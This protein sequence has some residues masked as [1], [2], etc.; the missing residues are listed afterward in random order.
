MWN[1]VKMSL[2]LVFSF[3]LILSL[4]KNIFDYQKKIQ[5][6]NSYKND[7]E[8]EKRKNLALKS[9]IQRSKDLYSKEADIR[10]KLNLLKPGELTVIIPITLTPTP[11]PQPKKEIFQQWLELF[12]K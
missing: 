1:K 11:P 2:F 7:P 9:Q 3:F 8:E 6:Y 12:I 10:N 4:S 5:F